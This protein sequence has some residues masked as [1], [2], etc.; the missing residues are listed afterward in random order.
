VER[1]A[2][3]N[4]IEDMQYKYYSIVCRV[5]PF[6]KEEEYIRKPIFNLNHTNQSMHFFS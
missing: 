3:E 6:G 2:G 4:G 1:E 5:V